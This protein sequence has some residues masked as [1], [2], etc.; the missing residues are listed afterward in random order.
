M[1]SKLLIISVFIGI[2]YTLASS[3]YFLVVDD[4]DSD[5]TVRRL[6]WRV[7]LS[8][9][10]ILVLWAGFHLGI[11]EPQGVNPVRYPSPEGG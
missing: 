8:V 7:G 5:R 6:S 2:L 3:F 10:L 4:G 1:L 9:G 11:I